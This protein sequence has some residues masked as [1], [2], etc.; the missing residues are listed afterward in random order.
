MYVSGRTSVCSY[1]IRR[2]FYESV[3]GHWSAEVIYIGRGIPKIF[4]YKQVK[5]SSTQVITAQGAK[6][7]YMGVVEL[8][9]RIRDFEKPWLFH[10]L[11]ELEYPCI[12]GI[13]FIGG[14]KIILDFDRKSLV[15]PD[16]QINKVVKTVEIEKK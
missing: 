10:V 1:F 11:A 14:S 5:K 16:S 2:N 13:D 3:M 15:I 9:I 8:N 7:R 6:C 4:F 12:L